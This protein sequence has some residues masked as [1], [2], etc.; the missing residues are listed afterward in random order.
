[1]PAIGRQY[2]EARH[3]LI[4]EPEEVLELDAQVVVLWPQ[5]NQVWL[6][7]REGNQLAITD[8]TEGVRVN[9]LREGQWLHLT[10]TKELPR[11]LH[12]SVID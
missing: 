8:K 6:E 1:M 5:F 4:G 3:P 12:A 10:I 2:W 11:V 7:T 9:S